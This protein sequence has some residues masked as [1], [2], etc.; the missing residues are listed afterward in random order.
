MAMFVARCF[1]KPA[2]VECTVAVEMVA[3]IAS[4]L[5]IA[6]LSSYL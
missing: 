4:L 3:Q 2:I 6:H 1:V 5:C